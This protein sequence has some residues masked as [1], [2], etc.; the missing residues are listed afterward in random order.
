MIKTNPC[1]QLKILI[2]AA[3]W[4][5]YQQTT[6]MLTTITF[7]C[8]HIWLLLLASSIQLSEACCH[9]PLALM[10]S[11]LATTTWCDGE[12]AAVTSMLGTDAE[13]RL[14]WWQL[15]DLRFWWP[16]IN[17]EKV[18]KIM[19][20]PP[21]FKIRHHR[22]VAN[23]SLSSTLLSALDVISFRLNHTSKT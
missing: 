3:E 13:D 14:R 21:T 2:I 6:W 20:L 19:I 12:F 8:W 11:F 22:N 4:L 18:I 5:S 17:I 16:M 10:N 23:I 7:F 9:Q 15:S 1:N